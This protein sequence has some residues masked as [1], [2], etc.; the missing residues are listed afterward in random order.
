MLSQARFYPAIRHTN[1]SQSYRETR[2][3]P[4]SQTMAQRTQRKHRQNDRICINHVVPTD[5]P[6]LSLYGDKRRTDAL[7][8]VSTAYASVVAKGAGGQ[9]KLTKMLPARASQYHPQMLTLCVPNFGG[10][11]RHSRALTLLT[12]PRTRAVLSGVY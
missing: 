3:H 8:C 7:V 9:N 12:Q 1:T 10:N 2:C 5:L 6:S 4:R 11:D